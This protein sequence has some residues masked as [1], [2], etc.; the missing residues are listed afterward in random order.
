MRALVVVEGN[1]GS[2]KSTASRELARRL[3]LRLM[4]E[5]VD[6][7]LLTLY[8]GDSTRWAFPFQMEMLHR[9]WASQM[10]AASETIAA[11]EYSGAILDRSLM[12]D[13]VFAKMLMES[14]KMHKK[15]WEIYTSALKNMLLVLF[16][17]TVLVYLATRPETCFERM[18]RRNRTQ[19]AQVSLD[20]LKSV[21]DG[22]QQLLG[23]AKT[24]SYPWSHA[25]TT[26]V[27]PW[28]VEITQDT[29]WDRL[30][31]TV[32]EAFTARSFNP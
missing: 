24:G 20:Y 3:N 21:H 6:D 13:L 10:S 28:D 29:E 31:E 23:G 15:E 8:Y 4:P 30:S 17:P 7:E 2:G 26:L 14:G 18:Q 22:Y 5:P 27:I 11:T 32:K 25:M 12:G 19:E 1:I 9:R 16:P